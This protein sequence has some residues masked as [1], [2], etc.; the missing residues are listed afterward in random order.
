[1]GKYKIA[2]IDK[3]GRKTKE[4]YYF[5]NPED[6]LKGAHEQIEKHSLV[7][8]NIAHTCINKVKPVRKP[9]NASLVVSDFDIE[10]ANSALNQ[11]R[12]CLFRFLAASEQLRRLQEETTTWSDAQKNGAEFNQ[13]NIMW[14]EHER[15]ELNKGVVN[16]QY[17]LIKV[18]EIDYELFTI[19]EMRFAKGL[20]LGEMMNLMA[21]SPRQMNRKIE[22]GIRLLAQIYRDL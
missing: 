21:Y 20:S 15:N 8:L 2:V 22:E 14:L 12:P 5:S 6:A 3:A 16:D 4:E 18:S 1:M 7:F 10:V 11:M 13:T 19:L 17:V 9:K